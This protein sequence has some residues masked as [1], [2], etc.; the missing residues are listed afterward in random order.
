MKPQ[1]LLAVFVLL[2][3]AWTPSG[4]P[5]MASNRT[6]VAARRPDPHSNRSAN[7]KLESAKGPSY[8][9]YETS[10][11]D[12]PDKF[13]SRLKVQRSVS[14]VKQVPRAISYDRTQLIGRS[15]NGKASWYCKA[16]V[17][18][19]HYRYPPGSMVAAAC[20]K[21]RTAMGPGWRGDTVQVRSSSGQQVTVRLVDWCGSRTK[22]IDLYWEPMRRLGGS[23]V[24]KVSVSW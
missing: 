18:I 20:Y 2:M 6:Q 15:V 12:P 19:C 1:A 8:V 24:L 4:P 16:G 3:L 9:I 22:L 21:L 23:G 11:T 14:R 17:S 13:D 10:R 5:E 7:D